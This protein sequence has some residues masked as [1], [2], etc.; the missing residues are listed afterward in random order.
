MSTASSRSWGFVRPFGLRSTEPTAFHVDRLSQVIARIAAAY[1][2]SADLVVMGSRGRGA[3]E[4]GTLGS[5]SQRVVS[6]ARTP[7]LVVH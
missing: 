4:G 5:L 2:T 1:C 6:T 7:V 3:L